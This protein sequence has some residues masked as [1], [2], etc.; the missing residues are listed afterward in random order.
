MK[1]DQRIISENVKM[2]LSWEFI[3]KQCAE[4]AQ[5]YNKYSLKY[6]RKSIWLLRP[7]ACSCYSRHSTFRS[8]LHLDF[9]TAQNM[10]QFTTFV[11]KVGE[12]R[13]HSSEKRIC[14]R[15]IMRLAE[16]DTLEKVYS[17]EL[18]N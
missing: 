15:Q 9:K 1:K 16:T 8:S 14:Y 11:S 7:E 13:L 2:S 18:A 3:W 10:Q 5:L 4:S 6:S 12:K 17:D